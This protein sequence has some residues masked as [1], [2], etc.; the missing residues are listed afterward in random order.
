VGENRRKN[1]RLR[2]EKMLSEFTVAGGTAERK[3]SPT[4][5]AMRYSLKSMGVQHHRHIT[6]PEKQLTVP[7]IRYDS[8]RSF[9]IGKKPCARDG[10][11]AVVYRDYMVIFGGDRHMMSF[12]DIFLFR[13]DK[14]LKNMQR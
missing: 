4:S 5:E 14:A 11:T 13:M 1:F 7:A 6:Q 12:N 9:L 10:Q 3:L 2:K 8:V